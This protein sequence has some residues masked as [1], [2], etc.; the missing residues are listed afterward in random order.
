VIHATDLDGGGKPGECGIFTF[1]AARRL[2]RLTR[3]WL[4]LN[5]RYLSHRLH[6]DY[7]AIAGA[8]TRAWNRLVA[9]A[10]RLTSLGSYSW[11]PRFK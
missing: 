5:E 8:A 7:E 2:G 10:G 11:I 6:A 4:Y 3:A 9:E 1:C